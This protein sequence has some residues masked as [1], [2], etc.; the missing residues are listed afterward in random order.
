MGASP[1]PGGARPVYAVKTTWSDTVLAPGGEGVFTCRRETS[2]MR[3]GREDLWSK[4]SCR[5]GSQRPKV[6]L[7]FP[8]RSRT[9]TAGNCAG[10]GRRAAPA[11]RNGGAKGS[12]AISLH[13]SRDHK[14]L[15]AA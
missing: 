13:A 5:L 10:N 1:G 4:T 11:P 8:D 6:E 9:N 7:H 3:A 2:A 14:I 12:T 15:A